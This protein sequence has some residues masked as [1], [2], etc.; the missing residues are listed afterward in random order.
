MEYLTEKDE[1]NIQKDLKK[2]MDEIKESALE[3]GI[4]FCEEDLQTLENAMLFA[5][6]KIKIKNK[7]KYTPKKYRTW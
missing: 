6:R 2:Q 3:Q 4:T 7:K 1:K 5:L